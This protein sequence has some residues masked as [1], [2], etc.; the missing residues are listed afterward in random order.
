[1]PRASKARETGCAYSLALEYGLLELFGRDSKWQGLAGAFQDPAMVRKALRASV[2]RIRKIFADVPTADARLQL[3]VGLTLDAL[4]R[5][6][7]RI[8]KDDD[9]L[10]ECIGALLHLVGYLLGLDWMT[11][12][13]NRTVLYVQTHRQLWYDDARR[14]PARALPENQLEVNE[15]KEIAAALFDKGLRIPE[16]ARVMNIGEAHAKSFLVW[17]ERIERK[18]KAPRPK[19]RRTAR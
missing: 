10:L 16:I 2:R 19:N 13:P 6:A 3:T 5:N 1:M 18:P 8:G 9:A 11:G 15:R 4:D 7:S 17:A 14:Y 12:K